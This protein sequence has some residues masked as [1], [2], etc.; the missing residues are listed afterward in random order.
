MNLAIQLY[1][2]ASAKPDKVAVLYGDTTVSYGKIVNQSAHIARILKDNYH[3]K[4]GD[5]IG[6]LIRNRP[7]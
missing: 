2:S 6:L 4:K 3:V 5:R 1:T 7:E